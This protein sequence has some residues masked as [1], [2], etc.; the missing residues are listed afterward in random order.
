MTMSGKG[1]VVQGIAVRSRRRVGAP[2][3]ISIGVR[4]GR[5]HYE[6]ST[7]RDQ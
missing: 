6:K 5:A 1:V 3:W 7:R 2:Q 4:R